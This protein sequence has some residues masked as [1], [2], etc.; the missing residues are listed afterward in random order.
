M[1]S[2]HG[3]TRHISVNANLIYSLANALASF[4]RI[5]L[6]CLTLSLKSSSSVESGSECAKSRKFWTTSAASSGRF[7]GDTRANRSSIAPRSAANA[8]GVSVTRCLLRLSMPSMSGANR[9]AGQPNPRPA[10]SRPTARPLPDFWAKRSAR[11]G[12]GG[13]RGFPPSYP[14]N[15]GTAAIKM[16]CPGRSSNNCGRDSIH[17]HPAGH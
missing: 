13:R 5:L 4:G 9:R 14:R 6:R 2:I 11:H 12:L 3:S 16:L 1:F 7:S 15:L 10:R 17:A 8:S